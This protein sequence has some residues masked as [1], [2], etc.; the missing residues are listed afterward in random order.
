MDT[1]DISP[2]KQILSA[3]DVLE[4]VRQWLR[5]QAGRTLLQFAYF[6]CTALDLR[7][8][9]GSYRDHACARALEELHR[10]GTLDLQA[11][12]RW[13]PPREKRPRKPRC[14]PEPVPL[15]EG[16]PDSVEKIGKIWIVRVKTDP[17]LLTWNTALETEHDIGATVPP[18]HALKLL[19]YSAHG[20]LACM[21]YSSAMDALALRDDWVDFTPEQRDSLAKKIIIFNSR[22]LIRTK[23]CRNLASKVI[24]MGEDFA[25]KVYRE[26]WNVDA[27][28]IE[29]FVNPEKHDGACYKAAGY[30]P[31]GLTEG[32][33]DNGESIRKDGET[34]VA[35]KMLFMKVLVPDFRERYG[36]G[37]PRGEN[38]P[39]PWFLQG[40]LGISE[41]L[42]GDVFMQEFAGSPLGDRR[43]SRRIARTAGLLYARPGNTVCGAARGGSSGGYA[44]M[45]GAYRIF[46]SEQAFGMDDVMQGHAH[47]TCRR[48]MAFERVYVAMDRTLLDF[49]SKPRTSRDMGDAG[50]NQTAAASRSIGIFSAWVSTEEGI[51]L[52]ILRSDCEVRGFWKKDDPKPREVPPEKTAPYIWLEFVLWMNGIARWMPKTKLCILCDR[53]SDFGGFLSEIQLLPNVEVIL[54]AKADRAV[55]GGSRRRH[56]LF[57]LMRAKEECAKMTVRVPR[58]VKQSRKREQAPGSARAARNAVLSVRMHRV[59]FRLHD[60]KSAPLW[61]VTAVELDKPKGLERVWWNLLTTRALES[62]E[63]AVKCVEDYARRWSIKE[64]HHVLKHGCKVEQLSLRE[65]DH[66]E[67]AIGVEEI[68]AWS[69]MLRHKL[70]REHPEL[71]PEAAFDDLE[72]AVLE[73]FS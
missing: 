53:E 22:L 3:P 29:T 31:V 21:C 64:F 27:C 33:G 37:R 4:K 10:A 46:E 8:A 54:R 1:H 41:S 32:R 50:R 52:G 42:D 26:E 71:P 24:A 14:L 20:L 61:A 67:R 34:A 51:P 60:G 28:L 11:S 2:L 44:E 63:D 66:I 39:P 68:V 6:L 36:I 35:P 7:N 25:R 57:R 19:F 23:G 43:R 15:P 55:E 69:F 18:G 40:P 58:I 62:P 12:L 5:E 38:L 73:V 9:D 59:A 49:S 13:E 72:V 45:K 17:E 65:P 47:R 70:G 30:E 16:V 48:M 56:S